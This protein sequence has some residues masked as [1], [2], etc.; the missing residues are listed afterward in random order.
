MALGATAGQIQFGVV[1]QTLRLALLG[2]AIGSAASFAVGR[3]IAALLFAVQ[4]AD[5]AIFTAMIAL[6]GAVAV[7]AG[8]IP[9]RRASHID[10]MAVLRGA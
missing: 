5:P 2:I 10:P 7:L 3:G 1:A 4:P 9:A 8:H 6:L